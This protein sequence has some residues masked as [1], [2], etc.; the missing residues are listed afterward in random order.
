MNKFVKSISALTAAAICFSIAGCGNKSAVNNE[1]VKVTIPEG[2]PVAAEYTDG[3]T[4]RIWSTFTPTAVQT[5]MNESKIKAYLEEATG[6]ST[7]YEHPAPGSE[8][9]AFSLMLASDDMPDIIR[10]GGW[11]NPQADEHIDTGAITDLTPWM[12][13]GAMPNLKKLFEEHPEW[14]EASKTYSGRYFYFP[15]ILGD[16]IL[17]SYRIYAIRQDILEKTGLEA[18]ETIEEWETY[19]A[20]AKE[21]GIK[22]PL[23]IPMN[24]WE[25]PFIGAFQVCDGFYQVDN[26]VKFGPYEE[27]FEQWIRTMAKWYANGWLDPEFVDQT[28]SRVNALVTNGDAGAFYGS[29]GGHLGTYLSAIDPASGIKL[30]AVKVPTH[31]KGERPMYN[32]SQY[33]VHSAGATVSGTSKHKELAMK[34]LDFGYSEEGQIMWNHGKEGESWNWAV[35][36]ET[37]EK[38]PK[39]EDIITSAE[40]RPEGASMGMM[41]GH[42][43]D[44]GNPVSVQ[45]KWYLLQNNATP[46]Q[47]KALQYC[48]D[49]DVEKY[50]LPN[51]AQY[52]PA[53]EYTE[54]NDKMTPIFTYIDEQVAKLIAGKVDLESGLEEYRKTLKDQGIEDVI[55]KY[56][57]LYDIYRNK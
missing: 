5:S 27:G 1:E 26:T 35:Y 30:D 24:Q 19:F 49:T 32:A 36:E 7:V 47:R 15:M 20:A 3:V 12:E 40:K 48:N 4:L 39:Y 37:G 13:A 43:C 57:E 10:Q 53:E 45:S 8:S 34:Y 50:Q 38:Y 17:K 44:T 55:A 42:Y 18:P 22:V 6:I 28:A 21:A 29:V 25:H 31:K 52:V 23:S 2:Y 54:I 9:D 46:Q 41:L 14:D 51:A 16:D 11:N 56:Q 33:S